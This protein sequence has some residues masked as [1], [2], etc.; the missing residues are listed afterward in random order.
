[1]TNEIIISGFGGQGIMLMGQILANSAMNMDKKVTF[2][3]SYGPEMRGGTANCTVVIS[4]EEIASPVVSNPSIVIAFNLPSYH[5]FK[6]ML[7]KN[8][9]LFYNSSLIELSDSQKKNKNEFA[10]PVSE[11]AQ[12]MGNIRVANIVMLG[13]FTARTKL[14]SDKIVKKQIESAFKKKG[15]SIVNINLQAF[16]EGIKLSQGNAK[17]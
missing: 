8:G 10:I 15:D 5:K 7:K 16:E 9:L 2:F 6:K 1:M 14:V 12:N 3:P 13:Y 11:I 17:K 4:D